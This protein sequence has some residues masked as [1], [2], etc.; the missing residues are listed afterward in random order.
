MPYSAA[1]DII[2]RSINGDQRAFK[3]L[4]E[5]YQAKAYAL[6]MR[7]LY[8]EKEAEDVVQES[9]LR[10]WRHLNSFDINRNF[11]TWLYRIVTNCCLDHLKAQRR[12]RRV[13]TYFEDGEGYSLE[14]ARPGD[15]EG[16][17]QSRELSDII[18]NLAGRLPR[19]QGTV[20]ILRDLQDLSVEEVAEVTGLS[21]GS[22]KT[23][24]HHARRRIRE[25]LQ[26]QYGME[27]IRR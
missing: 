2:T 9:F 22:I 12:W 11:G 16:E 25:Q 6:A 21:Q 24:L 26:K 4:V 3:E 19:K 17:S 27:E 14:A 5:T 18:Q 23:N 15:P 7:F 1:E 8:N 10:I 13:F 20:F